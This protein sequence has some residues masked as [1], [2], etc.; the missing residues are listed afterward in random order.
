[1]HKDDSTLFN[2]MTTETLDKI[3]LRPVNEWYGQTVDLPVHLIRPDPENLRDDFNENDLFD[4]GHNIKE[5]GQ[6]DEI[7]VFPILND[8]NMWAGSFDLHDG[9]RRWRAATLVGIN[10]LRAKIVHRPSREELLFKKLSRVLQTRSLTPEK[11]VSALEKVL[12]DLGIYDTPEAWESY[13]D[14]LGGGSEWPQ[15]TRVLLLTPRVRGLMH[16]G[17]I[18]FTLAQSIGRLPQARQVE[19]AEFVLS[20]K[21][22]GRFFSTEMVPYLL[23][24]PTATLAQ[25]FEHS[26][27]GG[28]RQFIKSP[29]QKGHE[30]PTNELVENFLDACVKWERSWEV[31]VQTRLVHDIK[32]NAELQYRIRD[33]ARRI[34]ERA[35]ALYNEVSKNR[36]DNELDYRPGELPTPRGAKRSD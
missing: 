32:G 33:A 14:K 28:W 22:N 4:L 7:T 26:R 13:R 5:I 9:E 6:L 15:L 8:E 20:N 19:A 17:T 21:I 29:Y 31:A 25:A 23:E 35:K 34:G 1:M 2:K 3:L 10:S 27:V 36:P 11:K 30:P 18:N 16:T 24:N 12:T